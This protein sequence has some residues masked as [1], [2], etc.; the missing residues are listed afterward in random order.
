MKVSPRKSVA[1]VLE[2]VICKTFGLIGCS[3]WFG[4]GL[5]YLTLLRP[6][7]ITLEY[8]KT[9]QYLRS[10]RK[11]RHLHLVSILNENNVIRNNFS[12]LSMNLFISLEG[13]RA[14]LW[15]SRKCRIVNSSKSSEPTLADY[16]QL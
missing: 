5:R 9:I 15:M 8:S 6:R 14:M 4:P 7:N 12:N 1:F 11:F 10:P 16:L 3:A 13:K 2:G